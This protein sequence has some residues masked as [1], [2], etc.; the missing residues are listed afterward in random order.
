[1]T[2][3]TLVNEIS[4]T[5]GAQPFRIEQ[6]VDEYSAVYVESAFRQCQALP[7]VP[8]SP[9]GWMFS[10]LR[11][12]RI[13]AEH[14]IEAKGAVGVE[15]MRE[16]YCRQQHLG[17]GTAATRLHET[18]LTGELAELAAQF[19]DGDPVCSVCGKAVL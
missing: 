19:P 3:E 11:S 17:K 1:M 13:Q 12:G 18:V 10:Q 8:Q 6:M 15:D 4:Q 9:I 16:R 5:F 14:V 2:D 7:S